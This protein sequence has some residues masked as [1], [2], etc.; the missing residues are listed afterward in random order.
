M[1]VINTLMNI[2]YCLFFCGN[3]KSTRMFDRLFV[4]LTVLIV[5][6]F[7]GY[8]WMLFV[9]FKHSGRVCSGDIARSSGEI[10]FD[11]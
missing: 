5:L 9:R 1:L 7:V 10:Q 11:G 3:K 6:N 2:S 8:F 4:A